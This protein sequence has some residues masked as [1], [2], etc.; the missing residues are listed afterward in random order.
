MKTRAIDW[1]KWD[2][3]LKSDEYTVDELAEMVG[4]SPKTIYNRR[5]YVARRYNTCA[6]SLSDRFDY[7]GWL[8]NEKARLGGTEALIREYGR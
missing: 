2:P 1:E 7:L 4:C 8:T 3:V 5:G 6:G